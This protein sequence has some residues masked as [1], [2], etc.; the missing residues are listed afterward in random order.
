APL[1]D[2]GGVWLNPHNAS[3]LSLNREKNSVEIRAE[4]KEFDDFLDQAAPGEYFYA[5]QLP[6]AAALKKVEQALKSDPAIATPGGALD[7]LHFNLRSLGSLWYE[8]E[9][10]TG[11][12]CR[13]YGPARNPGFI[14]TEADLAK[15]I[16][17]GL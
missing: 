17:D 8:D 15:S 14:N 16:F 4:S 10:E 6:D 13:K 3:I 11:F 1:L 12:R 7:N 5:V 9:G 2:L